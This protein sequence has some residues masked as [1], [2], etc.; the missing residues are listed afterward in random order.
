[1]LGNGWCETMCSDDAKRLCDIRGKMHKKVCIVADN[2]AL[3][4]FREYQD[5]KFDI[6]LKYMPDESP[7]SATDGDPFFLPFVLL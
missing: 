4:S 6:I 3:V 2:I 5:D 7:L 1:M